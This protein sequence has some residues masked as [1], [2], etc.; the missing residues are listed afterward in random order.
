M[1]EGGERPSLGLTQCVAL[2][3]SHGT[4]GWRLCSRGRE[5]GRQRV[6]LPAVVM[7]A[8][9]ADLLQGLCPARQRKVRA[10]DWPLW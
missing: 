5:G 6:V 9:P 3:K 8:L 10:E 2:G 7:T 1:R 4:D